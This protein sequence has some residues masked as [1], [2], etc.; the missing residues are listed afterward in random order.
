MSRTTARGRTR[1]SKARLRAAKAALAR[2]DEL[3]DEDWVRE[4]T[5]E[6]LRGAYK[7]RTRR[8]KARFDKGDAAMATERIEERSSAYQR[9]VREFLDAQRAEL[10]T[11][12]D[13]A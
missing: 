3:E 6:R 8:F 10:Q 12:R 4:D 7:Y 2:I 5:A 1:R 11:L 13:R 9:L